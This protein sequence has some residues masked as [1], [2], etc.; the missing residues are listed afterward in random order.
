MQSGV[1]TAHAI[2]LRPG[3]DLVPAIEAAASFA[4]STSQTSSAFVLTVVGSLDKVTLRMAN[5]CCKN[6]EEVESNE[7]RDWD[8]RMEVVSLVGTLAPSGKHLHM[9]LSDKDGLVVGGHLVAG[10]VYTTLELVLG[11]IQNVGFQRELDDA[12]GYRELV[13]KPTDHNE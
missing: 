11:T 4:M 3:D 8:E 6:A 9:S 7:I 13:I 5:A 2:R 1:I 12:T 10:R